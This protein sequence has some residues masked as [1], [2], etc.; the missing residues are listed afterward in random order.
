MRILTVKFARLFRV[1]NGDSLVE[2]RNSWPFGSVASHSH[3]HT[4]SCTDRL[5]SFQQA[6]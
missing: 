4:G 6:D 1:S 5:V 2:T 3:R